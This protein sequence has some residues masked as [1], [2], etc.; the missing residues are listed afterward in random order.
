[1]HRSL[2]ENCMTSTTRVSGVMEMRSDRTNGG[3]GRRG[4]G[5]ECVK[6]TPCSAY[7]VYIL[8]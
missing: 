6:G 8:L 1:M 7:V 5:E 3:T 4:Q 2:A